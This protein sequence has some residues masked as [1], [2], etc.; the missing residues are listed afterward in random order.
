MPRQ[1]LYIHKSVWPLRL[2]GLLTLLAML[3]AFG[4]GGLCPWWLQLSWLPAFYACYAACQCAPQRWLMQVGAQLWLRQDVAQQGSVPPDF[5]E[6][7]RQQLMPQS[8]I[9]WLGM[10]LYLQDAQGQCRWLWLFRDAMSDADYRCLARQIR[11]FRWQPVA[12]ASG[13][14]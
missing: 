3:S 12:A 1:T 4:A 13:W 2:S 10:W 11:Q 5:V 9:C 8:Q 14:Q 7:P 6:L